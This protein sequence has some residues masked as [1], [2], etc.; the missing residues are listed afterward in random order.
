MVDIFVKKF[1]LKNI[2]VVPSLGFVI[3]QWQKNAYSNDIKLSDR[4][5]ASGPTWLKH[6]LDM[7]EIKGSNSFRSIK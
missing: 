5:W 4:F 1:A 3:N 6:H 7:A 2:P